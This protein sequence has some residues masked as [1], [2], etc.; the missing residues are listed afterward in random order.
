MFSRRSIYIYYFVLAF[1]SVVLYSS[2]RGGVARAEG[3]TVIG[4]GTAAS[5][6]SNTAVNALS[7][8]V[9][10]GGT[11]DFDCGPDPV[12]INVNTN[13]TNQ[14]VTVNG[15]GLV[16]LSGE[17]LRQ[18]FYVMSGGSLTL[19]DLILS[20]GAANN[21]GALYVEPNAT[22]V[23]NRS[24]VN[25]S[26]STADGGGVYNWGALTLNNTTLGSN[27]AGL[28]GGG[29]FNNSGTVTINDSYLISN[30]GQN[31]G[32]A[33]TLN[34]QFILNRSAVRSSFISNQ[35][36]GIF[37]AGLTQITNSTFS[38]N[39]AL[40]GGAL[41]INFNSTVLNSTFNE[42]KADLGGAIWH[43]VAT[44]T[45]LKNSIV[46]GSL[47]SGGGGSSLNCDGPSLTSAG[48][49]IISDGTCLPNPG[50]SGDLFNTNP[51]LGIWFGTPIRGY[52]PNANSP[53]V[54]YGLGCPAVDQRGYPRPIGPA[55]DVGSMELGW[56]V[57]FPGVIR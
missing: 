54:D 11:I 13:I 36:G 40:T 5:C 45:S 2:Q 41:F 16:N 22:A 12:T 56:V 20:D 35:G 1:M 32:G 19:N 49:N 47:D 37:A 53:A 9:A 48:R 8:A 52:I 33:Y 25:G 7:N 42:N 44:N 24:F 46:A 6:Q 34:G 18:I 3:F 43:N 27:I 17:D 28:N 4:T 23:L 50:G 39:R 38:N 10:A 51:G 21:G 57:F 55:C 29:I 26:Q 31:G 15:G 14:D 30:Q